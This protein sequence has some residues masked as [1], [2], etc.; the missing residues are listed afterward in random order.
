MAETKRNAGNVT[1]KGGTFQ[2]GSTYKEDNNPPHQVRVD[3]FQISRYEITNYQF[4]LFLST[5]SQEEIKNGPPLYYACNWGIEG[6][7]P[8]PGY[9]AH[10]AIY[11]TWYGAQRYCAWAGG[12][13]PTEA[14]WEFAA[15]GPEG[16]LFP[17]ETE[18]V[19]S[20]K[21]C[22]F[23]NFKPDRG[24]YTEDGSLITSKCGSYSANSNGLFDM[25]GNVAE[26]TSTVYTE[27]GV[28]G[29]S[30]MNPE[31][32]YNAAK[33][34]P[35]RLKKKS[36]RGGSWKDPESMIR[37]VWRSYEYQNQPR[38]YIGFR[39]V[40]SVSGTTNRRK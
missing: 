26:W 2:M 21:D 3:S 1:V 18:D 35:Y 8:V 19:K 22:Y 40:R 33:E 28:D 15:R 30:D 29:M 9:E 36:V 34:D 7:K 6:G 17:W 32:K 16:A 24:D 38:S 13:L 10:P 11:V 39:C 23:A 14:E 4:A 25:A 27:S 31:L 37:S 20:E 12:R 5:L